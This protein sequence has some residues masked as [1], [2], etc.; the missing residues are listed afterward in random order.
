[1]VFEGSDACFAPVLSWSE[2]RGDAHNAARRSFIDIASVEQPAPAPRF[3]RTPGEVRR[4]PPERGEGG[5]QAL[6]DWGFD[7]SKIQQLAAQGLGM[8]E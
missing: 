7:A 1:K 6:A 8:G 5:H 4:A 3:S 2:A